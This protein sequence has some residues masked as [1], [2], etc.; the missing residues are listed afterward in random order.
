M[1]VDGGVN[2]PFLA[3]PE[4]R[5]AAAPAETL[6]P[7]G[8]IYILVN[9]GL[10]PDARTTVGTLRAILARTY[11]SASKASLRIHLAANAAFAARNGL[12]LYVS[13]IPREVESS[14]LDFSPEAM[15]RLFELGRSRALSGGGLAG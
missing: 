4:S 10:S 6:P 12:H 9:G 7:G 8:A 14:S 11:D 15:R 5:L 1:Y 2:A 13:A 3:V